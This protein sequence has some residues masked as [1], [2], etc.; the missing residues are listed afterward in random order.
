MIITV[1][2]GTFALFWILDPLGNLP[3][4]ISMIKYLEEKEIRK[5]L[6]IAS[7]FAFFIFIL[8]LF[9]GDLIFD[10]LN[11]KLEHIMVVGGMLL[12]LLGV[13]MMFGPE[14]EVLDYKNIAIVPLGLPLM[15]GPGSIATLL[16]ISATSGIDIAI[17]CMAIAMVL[18]YF[19]YMGAKLIIRISGKNT[20]KI[21]GY[22]AALV[23]ASFGVEMISRGLA[24]IR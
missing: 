14:K 18:Q 17:Y 21:M 1:L 10:Y 5:T 2:K 13:D 15:S 6:N 11:F 19:T 12:V 24:L 16:L 8:F 22:I 20:L 9:C 23:A 4:Y 3:I 7:L